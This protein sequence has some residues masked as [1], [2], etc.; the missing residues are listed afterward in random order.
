MAEYR[1]YHHT[2]RDR[3]RLY[4][5]VYGPEDEAR[6]PVLCLS[7]VTRNARDFHALALH[8][9][10]TRQ[11]VC[12]DYRGC[13]RSDRDLDPMNYQIETDTA[14]MIDLLDGIGVTRA[15]F[16]GTSR[17]GLVTMGVAAT[18]PQLIAAAVFNDIGPATRPGSRGKVGRYFELPYVYADWNEACAAF[19]TWSERTTPGLSDAQWMER[20]R[21]TFVETKDGR[22][23]FD[24]DPKL[25]EALRQRT[26][27]PP[28]NWARF[29]A[30]KDKPM[31]SLRGEWSVLLSPDTV[32]EMR[33][34]KPNLQAVTVPNR[35]HT[36]LL[37]EP[38][39]LAAIDAFLKDLP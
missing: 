12:P 2:T 30:M 6:L 25:G 14:D 36:P 31:L 10:A 28:D 32:E 20:A 16:L 29:E 35:G 26:G 13:G 5:R 1:E 15:I 34:R 18:R 24:Y 27:A 39:S 22:V 37:D 4:Y 38:E 9:R 8:L 11:V 3:L 19:R 23:R 7:G 33:T 21:A 17:G